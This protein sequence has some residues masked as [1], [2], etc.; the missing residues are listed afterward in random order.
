MRQRLFSHLTYANVMATLAVFLVLGGGTAVASYLIS[1]NNQVGPGT[2]S[3]HKAPSGYHAN[4]I[5]GS[6]NGQDV[7]DNTLGG[8]DINE[9]SLA[10]VPNADK[11]DGLDS[12]AFLRG[13]GKIAFFDTDFVF[14]DGRDHTL[15][16]LPWVKLTGNCGG[17]TL[18]WNLVDSPLEVYVDN[19]GPDP[20]HVRLRFSNERVGSPT[21][22]S[23]ESLTFSLEKSGKQATAYVFSYGRYVPILSGYECQ[24]E[25]Y[26]IV[27]AAGA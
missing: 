13:E 20:Q 23:G 6:V 22:L 24:Y 5:G 2:I 25:G 3:G 27:N 17:D 10:K 12:T 11:L 16:M 4:I 26:V 14:E 18:A 15:F 7:A 9:S 1:S 21:S 19:G 8:A